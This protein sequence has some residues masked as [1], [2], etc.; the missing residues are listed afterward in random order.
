MHN[1][2]GTERKVLLPMRKCFAQKKTF[3]ARILFSHKDLVFAQNVVF[4]RKEFCYLR[5]SF[6][7]ILSLVAC[8]AE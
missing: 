7:E 6:C 8:D 3:C 1:F 2:C 5:E 4:G